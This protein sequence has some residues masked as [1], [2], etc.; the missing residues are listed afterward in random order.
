MTNKEYVPYAINALKDAGK[1]ITEQAE[2]ICNDIEDNLVRGISIVIKFDG[3][4]APSMTIN[5][6]YN[7]RMIGDKNND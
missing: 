1:I 2:I 6:D 3:E 7:L 4:Y 5:K